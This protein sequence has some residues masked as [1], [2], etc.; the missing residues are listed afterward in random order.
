MV[1]P[2]ILRYLRSP[3]LQ[4]YPGYSSRPSR[5]RCEVVRQR[6]EHVY[7]LCP[8]AAQAIGLCLQSLIDGLGIEPFSDAR[9]FCGVRTE[10]DRRARDGWSEA[11]ENRGQGFVF[12]PSACRRGYRGLGRGMRAIARELCIGNCTV[13]RIVSVA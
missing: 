12:G 5:L 6:R 10:H 8:H 9:R 7:S 4:L 11:S 1:L 13:Q 3:I 2:L